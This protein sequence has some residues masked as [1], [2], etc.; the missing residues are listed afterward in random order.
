MNALKKRMIA[1]AEG[2]YNRIFPCSTRSNFDE[3]FTIEDNLII[4]W[5]NTEDDSTHM[6]ATDIPQV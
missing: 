2:K 5:F 1:E 3:S 4:F 6:I